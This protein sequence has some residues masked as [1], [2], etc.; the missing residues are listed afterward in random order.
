MPLKYCFFL[1][2]KFYLMGC[3]G[4]SA[5]VVHNVNL[6]DHGICLVTFVTCLPLSIL[7]FIYSGK[8]CW[9]C[10]LRFNNDLLNIHIVIYWELPCTD[11]V[12]SVTLTTI[13]ITFRFD[14]FRKIWIIPL[15]H[16]EFDIIEAAYFTIH[17][18]FLFAFSVKA[19]NNLNK[20]IGYF[21]GC[22]VFHEARLV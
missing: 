8:V 6:Q 22:E 5:G 17:K 16:L 21:Y 20:G 10:R 9:A 13:A 12:V 18:L 15:R 4:V 1:Y 11:T 19:Q 3:L 7:S 14:S 2:I